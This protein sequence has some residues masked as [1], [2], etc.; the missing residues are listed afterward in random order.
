M[1]R[2]I[3]YNFAKKYQNLTTIVGVII[4]V[5]INLENMEKLGNLKVSGEKSGKMCSCLWCATVSTE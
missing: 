5:A 3:E 4:R 1:S 2:K